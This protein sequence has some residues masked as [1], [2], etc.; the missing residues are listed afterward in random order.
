V[1]ERE[2]VTNKKKKKNLINLLFLF[3]K[4]KRRIKINNNAAVA[5]SL[6][7]IINLKILQLLKLRNKFMFFI[8]KHK[9]K[10][11]KMIEIYINKKRER[12]FLFK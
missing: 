8:V 2:D 3:K 11:R 12:T 1:S 5:F 6:I 9:I 7:I 10:R 4:K